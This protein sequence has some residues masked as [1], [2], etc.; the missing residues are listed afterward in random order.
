MGIKKRAPNRDVVDKLANEL[1]DKPYGEKP[2]RKDEQIVRTS[3]SLPA[4]MQ[5]ALEDLAIKNKRSGRE[6]R[7]VSAIV[8]E[9]VDEYLNN[10]S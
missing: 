9:A 6:L 7:T 2:E 8:R 1:A 10:N 5:G 3:L 4:S